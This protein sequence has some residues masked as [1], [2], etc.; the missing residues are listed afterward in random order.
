MAR[1]EVAINDTSL[2]A[3][4][5]LTKTV[6]AAGATGTDGYSF[7]GGKDSEKLRMIVVNAGA[8]GVYTIKKGDYC[9]NSAD[10]DVVVGGGGIAS[11]ITVDGAK[12]R[13]NDGSVYVDVGGVT[14]TFYVYQ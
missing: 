4:S 12:V 7:T 8:T 3:G 5:V 10:L 1:T 6:I 13:Q 11:V 9:A 2:N 14:G